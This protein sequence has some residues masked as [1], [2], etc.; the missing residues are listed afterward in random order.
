MNPGWQPLD[1][2]NWLA[3]LSAGEVVAAPAE[4]VYS[5]CRDPFSEAALRGL[6]N[7]KQRDPRKGLIVL[8]RHEC[9]LGE[10]C[11]ALGD[12]ELDAIATYRAK[13]QPPTTL[14][15]PAKQ[16]LSP[17]LTGGRDTLAI[18][19]ARVDSMLEYLAAWGRPLVSTSLN[20]SGEAPATEAAAIPAGVAALTLPTP[21]S[22][23]ASRIYDCAGKRWV[24]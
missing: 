14:I 12:T 9:E 6:I 18:R 24:R 7:V 21:L 13:G 10:L 3:A 17:L 16:A 5:Y 1:L 22:G 11:A 23:I 2:K 8:I 19:R 15:L 20:N 4:G